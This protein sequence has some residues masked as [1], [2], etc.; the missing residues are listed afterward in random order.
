MNIK[1]LY[2]VYFAILDCMTW[3]FGHDTSVMVGVSSDTVVLT[4]HSHTSSS[5]AHN[6]EYHVRSHIRNN[7]TGVSCEITWS[8]IYCI[9]GNFQHRKFQ[10]NDSFRELNFYKLHYSKICFGAAVNPR[11]QQN[12]LSSK[13]SPYT[14][15]GLSYEITWSQI[16][17]TITFTDA[18]TLL[19]RTC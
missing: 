5:T 16:I 15:T 18:I 1:I 7:I 8:Q 11:K 2:V 6:Q 9:V 13:T 17:K 14:V 12:L 10:V 19:L 4:W 3:W